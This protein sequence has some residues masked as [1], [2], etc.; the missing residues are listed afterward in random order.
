VNRVLIVGAGPAGLVLGN[1][2]RADSVD[3]VI[4]ERRSRSHVENR[5]RAG[6]LAANSVRILDEHRL[7]AGLHK[8]GQQHDTCAFRGEHGQFELRYSELGRGDIHTVYP[9]QNLVR[10]LIASFLDRGGEIHFE[11]PVEAVHDI[12]TGQP[13]VA[14]GG[15]RW[16][17]RFV[18]GADGQH[19][20]AQA[21]MPKVRRY[22]RD[23]QVSW[24]AILAE[25]PPSMA[26]VMYAI[27]PNGF[28]GHMARTP[29]VT[30]YYLQCSPGHDPSGRSDEQIW[31]ELSLRM[32]VDEYG[33][34]KQGPIIERRVV[35]MHSNVLDPIQ[36]GSLFL[37]GDAASLISP[38]AAKGANLAIMEA[39]ILGRAMIAALHGDE[40]PLARYSADCLPRIWR[41]QEFS[42][43]MINLLHGPSGD[44][45]EAV[46]F[47]ALQQA[48]L[49]SLRSSRAH[50]DHF[51]EHYIGI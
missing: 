3:C 8:H 14:A 21:A 10:D 51:A 47:R 13:W 49:A 4:L 29:S 40:R 35:D 41:A 27:H 24:L 37:V 31:D 15:E 34:L 20:V 45:D 11:T 26:S 50:Q 28:A 48:R 33:S 2:L 23:H 32:R 12:D 46:F 22:Q 44:D 9:Q 38:S 1:I 17:A 39:D 25:A 16:P 42:H 6:F 7:S 43:W 19:G 36:H 5:A 18:A 30:R